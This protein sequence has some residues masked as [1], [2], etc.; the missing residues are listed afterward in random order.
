MLMEALFRIAIKKKERKK[1]GRKEPVNRMGL[2]NKS[3]FFF[4]VTKF[5]TRTT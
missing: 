4:S 3:I 2:W 1:G 5:L